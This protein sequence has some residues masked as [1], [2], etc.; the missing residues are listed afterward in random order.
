MAQALKTD[1]KAAQIPVV[2]NVLCFICKT[3]PRKYTCKE[4][5]S[6]LCKGCCLSHNKR[7]ESENHTVTDIRDTCTV[8]YCLTHQDEKYTQF[9]TE[10]SKLICEKC[11]ATDHIGHKISTISSVADDMRHAGEKCV[12]LLNEKVDEMS[13]SLSCL[14]TE[15]LPTFKKEFQRQ[16][17]EIDDATQTIYDLLKLK[18][19][20][21]I[22]ELDD[23]KIN[24]DDDI[25]RFFKDQDNTLSDMANLQIRL[26]NVLREKHDATFITSYEYINKDFKQIEQEFGGFDKPEV[27]NRNLNELILDLLQLINTELDGK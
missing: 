12:K 6:E 26:D 17:A 15:K 27:P 24:H 10:C 22:K 16:Y 5:S 3:S 7:F 11:V 23:L 19:T 8:V 9:C 25:A 4:C 14:R 1:Y 2:K 21:K 13:E 20:M 18:Q